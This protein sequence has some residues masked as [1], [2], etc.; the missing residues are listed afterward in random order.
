MESLNVK[1]RSS[2]IIAVEI[3]TIKSRTR[4]EMLAA[5]I[6]IGERLTEAKELVNHGEWENW[7]EN[8]VDYSQSTAENLMRI[9]K[10]YGDNQIDLTGKSKSQT[11]EKLSYSQAC[12][13]FALPSSER[14]EFVENNDVEDMSSR[15]LAEAIS[16][17]KEAEEKLKKL[18]NENSKLQSNFEGTNRMAN[19]YMEKNSELQ[20]ELTKADN[21]HSKAISELMDRISELSEKAKEPQ[22]PSEEDIA[23]M[24]AVIKAK[25]EADLKAKSEQLTLDKETAERQSE[26]LKAKYEAEIKK[27]KLD[28]ESLI[29]AKEEAEKKL[30]L[31]APEVQKISAYSENIQLNFNSILSAINS[32]SI[33]NSETAEKLRGAIKNLLS[34]LSEEL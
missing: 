33:N 18:E 16:A 11:F 15:Q 1:A 26:E 31:T 21:E 5:S 25:V 12:A 13:L 34:K 6:E 24:K 28:S 29:K 8:E 20:K 22:G 30:S 23:K 27:A 4:K 14:A 32:L 9:F 3:N 7:L 2:E 19:Q 17:K 10:E